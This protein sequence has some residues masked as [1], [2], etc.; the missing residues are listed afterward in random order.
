MALS[1]KASHSGS[2]HSMV[3]TVRYRRARDSL[4]TLADP[5]LQPLEI[6]QYVRTPAAIAELRLFKSGAPRCKYGR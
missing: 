1:M 2:C 6:G 4:V 3:V 5:P